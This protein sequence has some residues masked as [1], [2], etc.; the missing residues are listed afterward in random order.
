VPGRGIA[1]LA[2]GLLL[3]AV[4][5]YWPT[6]A[7]LW[8]YWT[9][10]WGGDQGLLVV[11]ISAWLLYR[12]RYALGASPI[13]PALWSAPLLLLI[14]L[15]SVV[16]WKAGIQDLHLL[17]LPLLMLL[18]ILTAFG[19]SLARVTLVPIGFLYFAMP[20]WSSLAAPLQHLTVQIVATVAPVLGLPASVAGTLVSFPNGATFVVTK[21]CGGSVFLVQGL[22]VATLIGELESAS[23]RRRA[24]LLGLVTALALA[25]NWLRV[26]ALI[27]I[28]YTTQMRH[29][30]VARDHVLFGWVLFAI[31]L[32]A[33]AWVV[34]RRATPAAGHP[35]LASDM[36]NRWLPGYVMAVVGLVV[37]P[38]LASIMSL[39]HDAPGDFRLPA[40]QAA[41]QGPTK[42]SDGAWRPVFVGSHDQW[43]VLYADAAGR[44]VETF[45]IGYPMQEQGRE[46]VNEGN[47]LLGH[48]GLR[49]ITAGLVTEGGG[50]YIEETVADEGGQRSVVWYQYAID[51]R[52]FVIP[53]SSQLWYGVRS[54]SGTPYSALFAFR[55]GCAPS[56]SHARE[57][58]ADFARTMGPEF[59]RA[60][61]PAAS[62]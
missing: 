4:L 13:R 18:A 33:F 34:T 25:A 10:S 20:A 2:L 36:H 37:V 3:T 52:A 46:L 24:L 35:R 51:G 42:L 57:I 7:A 12:R 53:I 15:A 44:N 22:A 56:C 31:L 55:A 45:A 38:L 32:V 41:W 30:I 6:T 39:T 47:L 23:L 60:P 14:G 28:G 58:L 21:E 49:A 62:P 61:K 43:H 50:R 48:G 1:A 19:I 11:G 5:A 8:H 26:L 29:V 59:L 16:C 54:I 9:T 40:G 17:L 27:Y